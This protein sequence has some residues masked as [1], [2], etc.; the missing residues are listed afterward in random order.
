M[1][2][3][4]RFRVA[5]RGPGVPDYA[6][7][8]VFERFYSL[9]RPDGAAAATEVGPA[10]RRA[11]RQNRMVARR[12]LAN[13]MAS[14]TVCGVVAAGLRAGA[15]RHRHGL[16]RLH[17][18]FIVAPATIH[19]SPPASSPPGREGVMRLGLKI[20]MVVGAGAGDPDSRWR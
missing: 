1:A 9:P 13:A 11:G 20:A 10:V 17:P 2:T 18:R 6:R 16:V 15:R 19:P 14:G 4:L 7:E 8:R 5:D 3:P 12:C